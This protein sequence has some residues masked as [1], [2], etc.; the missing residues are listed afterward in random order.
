M[1]RLVGSCPS[2]QAVK[3]TETVID[4]IERGGTLMMRRRTSPRATRMSCQQ[5]W[6]MCQL[7]W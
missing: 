7:C 1:M 5:R 4:F 6:S 2:T 3:P